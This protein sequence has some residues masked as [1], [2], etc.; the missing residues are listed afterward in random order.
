MASWRVRPRTQKKKGESAKKE[1]HEK[2]RSRWA[3]ESGDGRRKL[4]G[5]WKGRRRVE[6]EPKVSWIWVIFRRGVSGG[7]IRAGRREPLGRC[8][9][10]NRRAGRARR[11]CGGFAPLEE[12][13]LPSCS[14]AR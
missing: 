12:F 3:K 10:Y 4:E 1:S 2:R 8:R 7:V 5:A 6:I 14:L 11:Q 13:R 9:G